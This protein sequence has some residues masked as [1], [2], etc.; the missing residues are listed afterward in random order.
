MY[1]PIWQPCRVPS[2]LR[3]CFRTPRALCLFLGSFPH[4]APVA[5]RGT[6]DKVG[7]R[8]LNRWKITQSYRGRPTRKG[9][10]RQIPPETLTLSEEFLS[11]KELYHQFHSSTR[12]FPP[13]ER[14][15]QPATCHTSV[16]QKFTKPLSQQGPQAVSSAAAIAQRNSLPEKGQG[17]N[18]P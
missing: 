10:R 4:S 3:L 15:R 1:E 14:R 16:P 8:C 13:V 6:V 18:L 7:K 17:D 9:P 2:F 11:P 5:F 12:G